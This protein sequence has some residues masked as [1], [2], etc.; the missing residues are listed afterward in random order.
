[1]LVEILLWMIRL[2]VQVYDKYF[3]V[4]YFVSV[5]F[6][7]KGFLNV[8]CNKTAKKTTLLA[9]LRVTFFVLL[10]LMLKETLCTYNVNIAGNRN[11]KI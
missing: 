9:R 4:D 10:P 3:F 8:F 6:R 5:G 11:P 2:M 7:L 1:M